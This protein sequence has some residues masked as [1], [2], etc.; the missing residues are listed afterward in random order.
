[1]L[2][3]LYF[4]RSPVRRNWPIAGC[5]RCLDWFV[6]AERLSKASV[7]TIFQRRRFGLD[8]SFH[9]IHPRHDRRLGGI[10][11][12]VPIGLPPVCHWME[13]I[14]FCRGKWNRK[15]ELSQKVMNT[16]CAT[17]ERGL[18]FYLDLEPTLVKHRHCTSSY[19]S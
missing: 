2:Y 16:P 15:L 14:F 12:V 4:A 6:I 5:L 18:I 7:R 8:I 9:Q 13:S 3:M 19:H 10:G 11:R 1:M 17:W